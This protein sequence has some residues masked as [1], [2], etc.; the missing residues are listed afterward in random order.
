MRFSTGSEGF[1][2]SRFTA[3][4]L[5]PSATV[6]HVHDGALAEEHAVS[7]TLESDASRNLMITVTVQLTSAQLVV[8]HWYRS[9]L[10]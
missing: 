10:C 6:V 2:L 4:S 1:H 7:S 8:V 5:L 3:E 9:L